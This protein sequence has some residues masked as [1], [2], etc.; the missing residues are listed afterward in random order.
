M[1]L[2]ITHFTVFS[3]KIEKFS[4]FSPALSVTLTH[5]LHGRGGKK[6]REFA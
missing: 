5:N 2:E 4:S 1:L 3:D 6:P